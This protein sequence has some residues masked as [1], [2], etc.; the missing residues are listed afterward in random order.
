MTIVVSRR[1]VLIGLASLCTLSIGGCTQAAFAQLRVIA[2]KT[3]PDVVSDIQAVLA[4]SGWSKEGSVYLHKSLPSTY[5]RFDECQ[6]VTQLLTFVI[7]GTDKFAVSDLLA[8]KSLVDSMQMKFGT[9]LE[10]D[11]ISSAGQSLLAA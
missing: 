9:A 5:V 2:N 3:R 10:Y 7:V 1:A 11:K 4:A 8:Y 6:T